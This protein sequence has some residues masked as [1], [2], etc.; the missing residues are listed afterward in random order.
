MAVAMAD[1]RKMSEILARTDE[2]TGLANRRRFIA[3][4]EEFQRSPGSLLILDLD[5]FKP[6][7]DQLGHDVGDQLL[8]QVARPLSV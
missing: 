7:N 3:E 1:A 8:A 6:V 4:F 5:G 2:L